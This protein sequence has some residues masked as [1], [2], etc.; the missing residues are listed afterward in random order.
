MMDD[1]R[2]LYEHIIQFLKPLIEETTRGSRN[3]ETITERPNSYSTTFE[4]QHWLSRIWGAC[5]PMTGV[6]HAPGA[7]SH[8]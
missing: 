7:D 4:V 8:S 5:P 2:P 3:G 1:G 6:W